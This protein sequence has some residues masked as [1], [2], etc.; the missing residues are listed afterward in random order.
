MVLPNY[1]RFILTACGHVRQGFLFRLVGLVGFVELLELLGLIG[2][3][4]LLADGSWL[5]AQSGE[6]SPDDG[7][8]TLLI[9]V[10]R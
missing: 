10:F 5:R 6:I 1:N 3:V 8:K 2:L 7:P 4:G 9:D